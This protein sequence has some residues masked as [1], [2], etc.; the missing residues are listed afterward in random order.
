M[1]VLKGVAG[2]FLPYVEAAPCSSHYAQSLQAVTDSSKLLYEVVGVCVA[3]IAAGCQVH[4]PSRDDPMQCVCALNM[5]QQVS[6]ITRLRTSKPEPVEC[7]RIEWVPL[8]QIHLPP[9]R[10]AETEADLAA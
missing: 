3:V 4:V 9:E 7:E 2:P 10:S 5:T 8:V 1:Q 6:S